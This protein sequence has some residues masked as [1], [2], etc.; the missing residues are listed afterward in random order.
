MGKSKERTT[1]EEIGRVIRRKR[2]TILTLTVI[3]FL[4]L[5]LR[6]YFYYEPAVEDGVRLSGND[7]YYHKRVI[8]H[9]QEDHTHLL[10]DPMIGYPGT[11]S[12]PGNPRPPLFDWSIAVIGLILAPIFGGDVV[13]S[14]NLVTIFTPSF[15][16]ALTVFP[17]YF[18]TREYFGK[19][20]GITA[21]LL[22]AIMPAHIDRSTLGFADHDSFVVF[23]SVVTFFFYARALRTMRTGTWVKNWRSIKEIRKGLSRYAE[24][25]RISLGY[26]FLSA[27]SLATIAL[28]WKGFSYVL[29]ILLIYYFIQL[30]INAFKHDD[31]LPIA[32]ITLIVFA[33]PLF[34][35]IPAYDAM[36]F[37]KSSWGLKPVFYLFM[38]VVGLT[39]LFVPTRD[40]PWLLLLPSIA[41]I[42]IITYL[43]MLLISPESA[44]LLFSGAGYFVKTKRFSTIAE[45]QAPILSRLIV[46]YGVT[47]FFL[48]LIGIVFAGLE[49][50][51]KW[52]ADELF[53]VVWA[54]VAIF[55]AISAI[56]FMFNASP[57]FAILQG[58]I[59]FWIIKK[60]NFRSITNALRGFKGSTIY[61]LRKGTKVRHIVVG[62]FVAFLVILPNVWFA[63]DAGIPFEDKQEYDE[64]IYNAMPEWI[65]PD[66]YERGRTVWYLGAFGQGFPSEYWQK[67]FEWLSEQDNDLEPEDRPAFL[68]WWDYGM[69]CVKIGDHPT[70]A[71]NF[72]NGH[73]MAG[74]FIAAEGEE[75][76]VALLVVRI[77]EK[78]VRTEK[79]VRALIAD[80]IG[81]DEMKTYVDAIKN[82]GDYIDEINEHPETYGRKEGLRK[83]NAKYTMATEVLMRNLD[84][85]ELVSLLADAE[86]ITGYAIRYFGVDS[87][88][89]PFSYYNTGIFY[90][91]ITLADHYVDDFLQ[92]MIVVDGE[93]ITPEEFEQRLALDPELQAENLVLA[94]TDKFYNTMFYKTYIGYNYQDLG[95]DEFN[96]IPGMSGQ[97]AQYPSLQGW[98]MKHFRL[99][100]KTAYWNPRNSTDLLFDEKDWQVV[101]YD[102]ALEYAE[103]EKGTVDLNSGLS[104]GVMMVKYYHGAIISGQVATDEGVG[105]EGATVTVYD[106]Y[107]IAHDSTTTEADGSY[108]LISPPG[109]NVTLVAS[110]G[111]Q[112]NPLDKSFETKLHEENF[113]ITEDQAERRKID[114]DGD[115]IHDYLITKDITVDSTTINGTLFWDTNHNSKVGKSEELIANT[116]V[117]LTGPNN[118]TA[119][120]NDTGFFSTG[121]LLEG[122]YTVSIE[123]DGVEIQLTETI[124]SDGADPITKDLPLQG[125]T[126]DGSVTDTENAEA[127]DI[128]VRLTDQEDDTV[129]SA[130]T[131]EDGEY[132]I[133]D[134]L[135]GRYS[136]C[137]KVEGNT[138]SPVFLDLQL[139]DRQTSDF[140]LT[141][142]EQ[143]EGTVWIDRNEDDKRS[144]DEGAAGARVLFYGKNG[145]QDVVYTVV[146][147]ED[148]VFKGDVPD[149]TYT[150]SVAYYEDGS[151]YISDSIVDT[152][153]TDDL[154]IE[155]LGS[156]TL[157]GHIFIETMIGSNVELVGVPADLYIDSGDKTWTGQANKRGNFSFELTKG[158]YIFRAEH[159]EGNKSFALS[160]DLSLT[161]DMVLDEQM[162]EA[163]EFVG[164]AYW[165]KDR[166]N[167][168]D[169]DE[170]MAGVTITFESSS[171]TFQT[172]T[173]SSYWYR[174]A[175][176]KDDY[177]ISVENA[178]AIELEAS[179]FSLGDLKFKPEEVTVRGTVW[180][181]GDFNMNMSNDEIAGS[182]LVIQFVPSNTTTEIEIDTEDGS[183]E[184]DL[185]P[186]AYKLVINAT[187]ADDHQYFYEGSMFIP[188]GTAEMEVDL[189][190]IKMV[191]FD[192]VLTKDGV[193]IDPDDVNEDGFFRVFDP[194]G[195]DDKSIPLDNEFVEDWINGGFIFPGTYTI[196]AAYD[197]EV[198][199]G[200]HDIHDS[201]ER[202]FELVP[203]TTYQGEILMKLREDTEDSVDFES[204]L[205]DFISEEG[206]TA[207]FSTEFDHI[208]DGYNYSVILPTGGTY[209][210]STNFTSTEDDHVY[211]IDQE[212]SP[213]DDLVLERYWRFRGTVFYDWNDDDDDAGEEVVGVELTMSNEEDSFTIV[214]DADGKFT[215]YM[216]Y[217]ADGR[218][219][220]TVG[221]PGYSERPNTGRIFVSELRENIELAADNVTVTGTIF[222][223]ENVDGLLDDDEEPTSIQ[224]QYTRISEENEHDPIPVTLNGSGETGR[225]W[226][227]LEPGNYEVTTDHGTYSTLEK[228]K[229]RIQESG[230][231]ESNVPLATKANVRGNLYYVNVSGEYV[232][233]DPDTFTNELIFKTEEKLEASPDIHGAFYSL[234]IPLGNYSINGRIETEE[235]GMDIEYRVNEQVELTEDTV[236]DLKFQQIVDKSFDL[237]WLEKKDDTARRDVNTSILYNIRLI[238]NA[239]ILENTIELSM[240]DGP[241]GWELQ[242]E[243]DEIVLGL[244][245]KRDLW[246]RVNISERSPA[247]EQ[248]VEVKARAT[249]EDS[250][251]E[252]TDLKVVVNEYYNMIMDA[253]APERG[254]LKGTTIPMD[255]MFINDGN[256]PDTFDIYLPDAP[257]GFNYTL[258]D[259]AGEPLEDTNNNTILDTGELEAYINKLIFVNV[260]ADDEA[261]G[262]H[263]I[264]VSGVNEIGLETSKTL[265]VSVTTP[266]ITVGDLSVK[267]RIDD[268]IN[269]TVFLNVTIYNN[270]SLRAE[271]MDLRFTRDGKDIVYDRAALLMDGEPLEDR[272]IVI[273]IPSARTFSLKINMTGDGYH[274][275]GLKVSLINST[276]S[277]R[278]DNYVE[279]TAFV[280]E[281]GTEE[282]EEG[283]PVLVGIIVI[284]VLLVIYMFYRRRRRW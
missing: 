219:N 258:T 29:A 39:I 65:R 47:T 225:Y 48:A 9:V 99:I 112:F 69:W 46:S 247:G 20:A 10:E 228:T 253:P 79:N 140:V 135:P 232:Q 66:D 58:Y 51:K 72:M 196:W 55:M 27:F 95:M 249:G 193:P 109:E 161:E 165:D 45:A 28:A 240:D 216:P 61:A 190:A 81:E 6:A 256:N 57:V 269:R 143:V 230:K 155:L 160:L 243:E 18:F 158:D 70:V 146:A 169:E 22:L 94:Y 275:F 223:D 178:P 37:L 60:T 136:L 30:L 203:A 125:A 205:I 44:D 229:V 127:A 106:E 212:I 126:V 25:N 177:T 251:T 164:R 265:T 118:L 194:Y 184:L 38:G 218:Y 166:D 206:G 124:E 107:M 76:A 105:I 33:I 278:S 179:S 102:D 282:A 142:T 98:G 217:G 281:K 236:L 145:D 180:W 259:D 103:Q 227:S 84:L 49:F 154:E 257:E 78:K 31:S 96:G 214:T 131:N 8:D 104:S 14:T 237:K 89:F 54:F 23:F 32:A 181:D 75:E 183:F 26:A 262:N 120:T 133:N 88:M 156:V 157:R 213:F 100:Y 121:S 263:T 35:S 116:E 279:T 90:A 83:G 197:G 254:M 87:R 241:D 276:D 108:S 62:L 82:S 129:Y 200:S 264:Q 19:K 186:G 4:A 201:E 171:R 152:S 226:I 16:S 86:E 233:L 1:L 40:V 97:L 238:N 159:T 284:L 91:P 176:P 64:K 77:T 274:T 93:V 141:S 128:E 268:D 67:G 221:T 115:G 283:S 132:T 271:D 260:T 242:F 199:L 162:N 63:V 187:D 195:P 53:I 270:G 170:G 163:K 134:V 198:Y 175:I 123:L 144:V 235:Y 7:P 137:P 188:Y 153:S 150:V 68:S 56:R 3:F 266:D 192:P 73:E 151:S 148:G 248:E 50:K 130:T 147:D 273:E 122:E 222:V 42:G 110:K 209:T 149:D 24:S 139:G 244:E 101:S 220:I 138:S 17:V 172:V 13:T 255:I 280:G 117:R 74:N 191:Y 252:T 167:I 114:S 202:T 182:D 272:D 211:V 34:L 204:F 173:D 59:L 208:N 207:K 119:I 185:S 12:D 43:V 52:Q 111:G 15:W 113:T 21:A 11:G 231:Q 189:L 250:V 245:E 277:K 210:A 174:I 92:T 234:D 261:A 5:F 36:G 85:E 80:Y 168:M 71:D 239:N 267:Q 224:V 215:E 41:L 246:V 2:W